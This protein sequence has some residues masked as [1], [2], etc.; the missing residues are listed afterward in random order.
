M[1][2][3]FARNIIRRRIALK[4]CRKFD[5]RDILPHGSYLV[6][7]ANPDAEKRGKAYESFLDELKRCEQLGIQLHNFQY[8]YPTIANVDRCSPGSATDKDSGIKLIAECINRAHSET[9]SVKIVL[10]NSAGGAN[11]IGTRF[12]DLR[13]IIDHVKGFVLS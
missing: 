6:N 4:V 5:R 2:F 10:E 12:E 13:G 8:P 11:S 7:L 3:V 9:E 1:N